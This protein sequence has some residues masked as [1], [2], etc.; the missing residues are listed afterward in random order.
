MNIMVVAPQK[1]SVSCR[2]VCLSQSVGYGHTE[3]QVSPLTGFTIT[4]TLY[5]EWPDGTITGKAEK[6]GDITMN[7]EGDNLEKLYREYFPKIYNFFFY[8]LLHREDAEDLTAQTFLK[9]AE[10]LYT[11][12]PEK[13]KLNTWIGRISENT[14][15]DFYRTGKKTLPLDDE[16]S[17]IGNA[18][19]VSFEE[20]YA[21]IANPLRKEIYAALCQLPERDRMLVYHKYLLGESYH[22]I[23]EKFQINESTLAS[24]LQRA[25]AKLRKNLERSRVELL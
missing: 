11:Y 5:K 3:P 20:Q 25:K 7:N 19:S 24:A 15:I 16:L 14:L 6:G 4:R 17:G 21:Q 8:K 10:K 23:A 1:A 2:C 18:L 9:I 13:A 12:N 22:E